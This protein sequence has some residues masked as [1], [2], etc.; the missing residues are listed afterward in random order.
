LISTDHPFTSYH[1]IANEPEDVGSHTATEARNYD[2]ER[3]ERDWGDV[4]MPCYRR[5]LSA[6]FAPLTEAGLQVD[7]LREPE[8]TTRTEHT[9]YFLESTPRFIVLRATLPA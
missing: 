2:V 1:T 8:P 4:A 9:E 5:S 6:P 3:Y 7:A